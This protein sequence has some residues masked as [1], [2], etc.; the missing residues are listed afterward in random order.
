MLI[1][2]TEQ[3]I[4]EAVFVFAC[5][6]VAIS[7]KQVSIWLS[8]IVWIIGLLMLLRISLQMSESIKD[9]EKQQYKEDKQWPLI[10]VKGVSDSDTYGK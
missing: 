5:A 3:F 1:G 9:Q 6:L 8:G 10:K 2:S 4:P 7:M